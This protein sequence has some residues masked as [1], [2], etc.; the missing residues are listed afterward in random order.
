MQT[1]EQLRALRP[2]R[3]TLEEIFLSAVAEQN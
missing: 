3:S 1:G 2:R